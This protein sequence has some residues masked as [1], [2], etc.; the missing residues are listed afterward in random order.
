MKVAVS[1]PDPV[2][3]A[4]ED[5]AR[6]LGKSRSQIYADALSEYLQEHRSDAV[7]ERLNAV[8][9]VPG[10]ALEPELERM[11]LDTLDDEAW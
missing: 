11:A 5:L 6:R 9:A 1:I 4:A 3:E 10:P 7:T 2:F 8:Y